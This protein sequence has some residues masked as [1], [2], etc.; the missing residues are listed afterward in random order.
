[1]TDTSYLYQY[2]LDKSTNDNKKESLSAKRDDDTEA[3]KPARKS[4]QE[5]K[6]A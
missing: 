3:E 4:K 2:F 6:G 5:V 1:M